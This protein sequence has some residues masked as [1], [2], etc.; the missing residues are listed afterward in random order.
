[1]TKE[2]KELLLKDL[3]TRLPYNVEVHIKGEY[4]TPRTIYAVHIEDKTIG[5]FKGLNY[6]EELIENVKPYLRPM[7]SMTQEECEELSKLKP[8]YDEVESWKYIKTPVPLYI[9]NIKQFDFF[10]SHY[11]DWRGLIPKGLAL[12]APKNM[13]K[14]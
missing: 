6:N 5:Y 11:L 4:K 12:E 9:A 1:M 8:I 10:N 7:S 3:C 2:D 14:F 13:Y